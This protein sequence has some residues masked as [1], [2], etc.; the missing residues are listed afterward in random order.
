MIGDND[1]TMST[2]NKYYTVAQVAELFSVA[3]STVVTMIKD[4]RL[5][6]K[7]KDKK[8]YIITEESIK[9]LVLGDKS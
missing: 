8:S 2:D 9:R 3:Q 4:G 7:K 6:G 5:D 1:I